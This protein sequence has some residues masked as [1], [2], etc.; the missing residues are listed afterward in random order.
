MECIYCCTASVES[1]RVG[2]SQKKQMKNIEY[3]DIFKYYI[4]LS[5]VSF[6]GPQAHVALLYTKFVQ[7]T[8]WLTDIEFTE[9]F[10]I[11]QSLPGP[12]STQLAYS[13]ALVRGGAVKGLLAFCLWALPGTVVMTLFG[14]GIKSIFCILLIHFC[15]CR[16]GWFI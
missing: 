2:A 5:L 8:N 1:P 4:P 7:E 11:A 10:A 9:L 14:Y 12:A 15:S 13:I 6:G 3:L 16:I